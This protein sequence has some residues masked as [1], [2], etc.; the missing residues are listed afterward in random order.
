MGG[1]ERYPSTPP[2]KRWV[3]LRS[4]HPTRSNLRRP[5]RAQERADLAHRQRNPLLRLLP[6]K[7]ADLGIRRQHRRLHRDVVGMRR[8]IV[9]QH[10]YRRLALADEIAVYREDE[11]RIVAI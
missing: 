3:S 2:L 5:V 6:R 7:Q 1:A 9:G 10:Q 8:D 11:I 4:T